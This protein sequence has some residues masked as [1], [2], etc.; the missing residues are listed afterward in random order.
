M[1]KAPACF[2]VIVS[3]SPGSWYQYFFQT[4]NSKTGHNYALLIPQHMYI[5]CDLL[6]CCIF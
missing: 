5:Y 3:P 1:S 4:H 2:G 6:Y